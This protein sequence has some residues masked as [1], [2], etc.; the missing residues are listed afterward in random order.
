LGRPPK[1]PEINAAHK[2]QLSADQRRRNVVE[3]VFGSGK[4]KYSLKRIMARLAHGAATSISMSFL[5]M[6]AEKILMLLGL[7]F[8]FIF[9][10][11]CSLLRLHASPGKAWTSTEERWNDWLVTASTWP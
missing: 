6:S 9:A 1:D 10:C 4:R 11:L 3:G 5:V 8:V 2:Q 7:I